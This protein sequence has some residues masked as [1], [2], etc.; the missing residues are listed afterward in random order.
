[1]TMTETEIYENVRKSY[2][3]RTNSEDV[4]IKLHIMKIKEDNERNN[5]SRKSVTWSA[6]PSASL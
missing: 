3:I 5:N 6:I 4:E 1:M 2:F